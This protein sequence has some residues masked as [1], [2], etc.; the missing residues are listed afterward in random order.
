MK[1]VEVDHGCTLHAVARHKG[2][3]RRTE[4]A[5]HADTTAILATL[6]STVHAKP[7]LSRQ[8]CFSQERD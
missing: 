7:V 3:G 6:Q 1:T 4:N 2:P 8:A 5:K